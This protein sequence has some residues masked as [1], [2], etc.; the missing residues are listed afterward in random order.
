[1]AHTLE[2][3]GL[4]GNEVKSR[5][6]KRK[7]ARENILGSIA[8]QV[9][10]REPQ[11]KRYSKEDEISSTSRTHFRLCP[12]VSGSKKMIWRVTEPRSERV[13]EKRRQGIAR[14][15]MNGQVG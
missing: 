12:Y 2:R 3:E 6:A 9:E 5:T 7:H 4:V 10:S 8:F 11:S 1:M 14:E 15:R 13:D